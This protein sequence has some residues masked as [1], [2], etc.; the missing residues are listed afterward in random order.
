MSANPPNDSAAS[1]EYPPS[2]PWQ[3]YPPQPASEPTYPPPAPAYPAPLGYSSAPVYPPSPNDYTQP[4][5][6]AQPVAPQYVP[7]MGA[8][9]YPSAPLGSPYPAPGYGQPAYPSMPMGSPYM[10][11]GYP[12]GAPVPT[13]SSGMAIASVIC[14]IV[15]A[16]IVVAG[17]LIGALVAG[18]GA[19]AFTSTQEQ[20]AMV[21]LFTGVG[22]FIALL[23]SI[24]AVVTGHIGLGR[25]N[26]SGGAV[27][28]R[29]A[30]LTG[31]ILGYCEIAIPLLC[32]VIFIALAVAAANGG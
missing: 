24:P 22:G 12:Y 6:T 19:G 14:G 21:P 16:V 20:A 2:Q 7:P 25:I 26:R 31:V 13:G 11:A 15:G 17:L 28:G 29:G 10:A 5:Q 27:S 32:T 3:G 9:A 30:A 4:A 8:P 18:T 1:P 23:A